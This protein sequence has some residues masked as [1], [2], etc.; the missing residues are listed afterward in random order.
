MACVVA[1]CACRLMTDELCVARRSGLYSREKARRTSTSVVRQCK[2]LYGIDPNYSCR[3]FGRLLPASHDYRIV[4]T[5]D[6]DVPVQYKYGS[7]GGGTV[8]PGCTRTRTSSPARHKCFCIE[9]CFAFLAVP[10]VRQ[11]QFA[12]CHKIWPYRR[13][14]VAAI[15]RKT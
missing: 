6:T 3:V 13:D 15:L 4:P 2:D 9:M 14:A 1:R 11:S 7:K 10:S 8:P 5:R 12:V